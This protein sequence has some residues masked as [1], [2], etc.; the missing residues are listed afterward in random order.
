MTSTISKCVK[1]YKSTLWGLTGAIADTTSALVLEE[2]HSAI[3]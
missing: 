2:F 3:I 1:S